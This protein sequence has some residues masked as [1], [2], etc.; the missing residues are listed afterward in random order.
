[1]LLTDYDVI[2]IGG[3][4]IGSTYAYK[5]A[6]LGYNVGLFEQKNRVGEPLQCAGLVSTNIDDTKNLPRD[7]IFNEIYG[8]NLISP[9]QTKVTVSRSKPVAYVLDRVLYD[10]Y[11]FDRAADA[12]VDIHYGTKVDEVNIEKTTIRSSRDIY[13]ASMIAVST[14]PSDDL[15]KSI[16]PDLEF[17]SY[18]GMQYT[19]Q[20]PLNDVR[21]VDV[22]ISRDILPGFIWRIPVSP[23][24]VRLGLFSDISFQDASRILSSYVNTDESILQKHYGTI[25]KFNSEKRI[26]KNNTILLGDTASQVKPTTGGGL[27]VGFN[28]CDIAS[29]NSDL[30]LT[31]NDNTYLEK[32]EKE[33]HERYDG[34]FRTQRNVMNIFEDLTEDDY[35]YMFD[36]IEKYDLSTVISEYGDMDSQIPLLKELVK[37]GVIFKLV[38]KIGVRRLT[39]IWRSQ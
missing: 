23:T 6:K 28:C 38:P 17:E 19:L 8:A 7:Y 21:F 29:K 24:K 35:N 15:V 36:Q 39:N 10:K 26:T 2:V 32:Y 18:L 20:T 4:P 25:P 1:M 13:S 27:V 22:N 14:G 9:N 3:G 12:G 30:M 11:L 33:Y 5:M 16:N 31:N 34:E 37:S